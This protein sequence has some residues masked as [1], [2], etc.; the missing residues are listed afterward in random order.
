MRGYV[1]RLLRGQYQVVT[2]PDGEAALQS[3]RARRPDLILSDIM[4]PRM[5]GFGLLKA[6]RE[7]ETLKNI[8]VIL[9][10][11]RAGEEP[12]IEGLAAGADD[13]LIKPFSARELLRSE[14]HTSELQSHVN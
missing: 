13:Y 11:A 2:V 12:R 1:Q 10:S 5:D 9:L 3:A 7:E 8:P 4:M 14:E 6:I